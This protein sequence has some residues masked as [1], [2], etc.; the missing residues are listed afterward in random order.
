[1][2]KNKSEEKKERLS[3]IAVVPV[4]QCYRHCYLIYSVIIK[5][6]FLKSLMNKTIRLINVMKLIE[7]CLSFLEIKIVFMLY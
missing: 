6:Y 3:K 5:S 2:Y 7:F 1:M 4:P